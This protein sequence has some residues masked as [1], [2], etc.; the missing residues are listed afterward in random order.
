MPGPG[1][2]GR[3]GSSARRRPRTRRSAAE[4]AVRGTLAIA[5][6]AL[7]FAG[8]TRTLAY[9]VRAGDPERAHAMAPGDG[10]ITALAAQK[11]AGL[12]ASAA[13]RARSDRLARRAL[14][15]E[16]T[17]VAAA[18]TLGLNAEIRGDVA[19]ARRLFGHAER[20]SRR[21]LQTQLWSVEDAVRRGDVA[22][23]LRHYDIALR[24]SRVAP[25]LLFPVLGSAIADP[26]IRTALAGTLKGRP[27][28]GPGFI[29]HVAANGREPRATAGLFLAL[30]RSGVPVSET[31]RAAVIGALLTRDLTDAAWSF[32]AAGRP[33][34]DRRRSRDPGF[35][36]DLVEPSLF[37]W[38]TI[39]DGRVTA[40]IQRGGDPGAGGGGIVDF[41]APASVGGALLQQ[42]QVLPPGD[43]R[44]EGR[45]AGIEQPE[46]ARP[47]WALSCRDGRELGRVVLPD[48][49][50]AK[51]RFAG[52][53]SVPAGCPA[54]V[55]ALVAR[56]SDA[57]G[58][59]SG[60]I[61]RVLLSPAR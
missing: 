6:A 48:S 27:L 4:W 22:G 60:Q 12:E 5:A 34:A 41:A 42:L 31:A 37:D 43:Y 16:P 57:V 46:G 7:G 20:L 33:D 17:A 28:W 36:A 50:Q 52:R 1:S 55:L 18:A 44:I 8:V 9:S 38:A 13:D 61:E 51:G 24:T 2:S 14:L 15:Q 54:Q 10:R 3:R 53:F 26:A 29:D 23:A 45:S 56:P 21:D 59:L 49:A 35:T 40:S 47:Y 58:G 32:Y 39:N 11:L 30:R 25:D 19:S